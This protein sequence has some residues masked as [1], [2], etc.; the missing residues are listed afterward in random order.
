MPKNVS[1]GTKV[2]GFYR[3]AVCKLPVLEAYH[4]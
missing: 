1:F 3:A 4:V 2:I